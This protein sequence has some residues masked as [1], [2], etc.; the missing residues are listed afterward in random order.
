MAKLTLHLLSLNSIKT[1]PDGKLSLPSDLSNI[2]RMMDRPGRTEFYDNLPL[3]R[4]DIVT[5]T[6]GLR[7]I[8]LNK[9]QLSHLPKRES[10][11]INVEYHHKL[12]RTDKLYKNV[13]NK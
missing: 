5:E 1:E 3:Q 8:N 6:Q 9:P 13:R 2:Q 11:T 12:L 10:I 4:K 7:F